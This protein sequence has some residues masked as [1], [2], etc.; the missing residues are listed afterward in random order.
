MLTTDLTKVAQADTTAR[1]IENIRQLIFVVCIFKRKEPFYFSLVQMYLANNLV[2]CSYGVVRLCGG[3]SNDGEV[4]NCS[5]ILLE[6][7]GFE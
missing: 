7:C 4:E 5:S 3:C 2:D 1:M 6:I